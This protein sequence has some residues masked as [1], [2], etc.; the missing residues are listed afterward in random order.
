LKNY[1][2][3]IKDSFAKTKSKHRRDRA[4]PPTATYEDIKAYQDKVEKDEITPQGLPPCP[5]CE[6]ESRFFK[7][8]AYRERRFLIIVE[9]IVTSVWCALIRFK[10]PGC[11]KSFTFYPDFA[12][13][14]KHYTRQTIMGLAEAYVANGQ[15]SYEKAVEPEAAGSP[16]Y[17]DGH[18]SLAPSTVHRWVTSLCQLKQTAR[19]AL[20]LI[21]Q[22]EPATSVSRVLARLDIPGSKY[23]SRPRRDQ[24][25]GCLRL[26]LVETFFKQLFGLSIFTRLATAWGFS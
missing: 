14:R 25:L 7:I 20:E 26:V 22:Q 23:R 9:M 12:L 3:C 1:P 15:S 10:C 4:M 2:F 5:V 19:T 17:P 21:H 8:H 24:L 16:E 6:T 13:P 18:R 11:R